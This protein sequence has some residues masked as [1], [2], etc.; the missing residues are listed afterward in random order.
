MGT[1]IVSNSECW[2]TAKFTPIILE[3]CGIREYTFN[4]LTEVEGVV[5]GNKSKDFAGVPVNRQIRWRNL[6]HKK[7]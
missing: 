3:A 2:N 1:N 4:G 7:M 6:T 5:S